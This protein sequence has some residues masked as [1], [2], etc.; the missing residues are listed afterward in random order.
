MRPLAV[1]PCVEP[2]MC[3]EPLPSDTQASLSQ[4]LEQFPA[5]LA[6][7]T[8]QRQDAVPCANSE[9]CAEDE[10]RVEDVASQLAVSE[11]E[12]AFDGAAGAPAQANLT[13]NQADVACSPRYMPA[14]ADACVGEDVVNA[15]EACTNPQSALPSSEVVRDNLNRVR[16]PKRREKERAQRL[17]DAL[18]QAFSE[19][20]LQQKR[21]AFSLLK[22]SREA[23]IERQS[24]AL[25]KHQERLSLA[26]L[27]PIGGPDG[28]GERKSSQPDHDVVAAS[29]RTSLRTPEGRSLSCTELLP[30]SEGRP[31]T[32]PICAE[33]RPLSRH[34]YGIVTDGARLEDFS[35]QRC[36]L[37]S[38]LAGPSRSAQPKVPDILEGRPRPSCTIRRRL[39]AG[40]FTSSVDGVQ[41]RACDDAG[42]HA[43]S[44]ANRVAMP[45]SSPPLHR[46]ATSAGSPMCDRRSFH[47]TGSVVSGLG[48]DRGLAC[49]PGAGA[50]A[51]QMELRWQE[52]HSKTFASKRPIQRPLRTTPKRDPSSVTLLDE[53]RAG[54]AESHIHAAS[55]GLPLI[56]RPD[57]RSISKFAAERMASSAGA[58]SPLP[59]RF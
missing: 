35:R 21:R 42:I 15:G 22:K 52:A 10:E 40:P 50:C 39:F 47:R 6:D 57:S 11:R 17:G 12:V 1:E 45:A 56:Q 44:S 37:A 4:S 23:R 41:N 43:T 8:T 33:V 14:F 28:I 34:G 48:A 19:A 32:S 20:P 31:R 46:P 3:K 38:P 9:G 5:P 36:P 51:K 58:G 30:L 53:A 54:C 55:F 27:R 49:L 13:G 16:R 7:S 29:A 26:R 18:E 25:R 24:D 59:A 2:A